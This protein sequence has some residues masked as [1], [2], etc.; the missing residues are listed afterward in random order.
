MTASLRDRP[1]ASDPLRRDVHA[2][3][4]LAFGLSAFLVAVLVFSIGPYSGSGDTEPA[5]LLPISILEDGRL[6]F[7]RFYSDRSDLPY[8]FRRVRGRVVSAYPIAA[9]IANVPAF[10][11]A[12]LFGVDLSA[13][14]LLLSHAT[15]SLLASASVVLLFLALRKICADDRQAFFFT[16]VYA[17]G[18]EVWS[19][20][21]RGLW[22]HGPSLFFLCASL[23]LLL[24]DDPRSIALAGCTLGLAVVSRPTDALI[25]VPAA[26]WVLLRRRRAF[27]PFLLLAAIPLAAVVLYS[28]RLLGDP[29]AFGQLYRAGGW[30]GRILPG[31][32]GLLVSPSRGLFVFSPVLLASVAGAV[33]VARSRDPRHEL[34]RWLLPGAAG[35][36]AIYSAWGMWWGG[37]SF[38]YRILLDLVPVLVLLA[39]VSWTE[40]IGRRLA[41]RAV[42]VVLFAVSAYV[43]VLGVWTYPTA[44]D[45]GLDLEP[46]RLWNVRDSELVLASRKLFH[47]GGAAA[48][49]G[50]PAVWWTRENEDDTIPGWLE[51]SPGGKTVVG[52]LE[53]SGWAQSAS[54]DV[55]VAIGL[56]D[57]R[58]VRPERFAR[59]DVAWAVPE[60]ADASR[61]GFRATLPPGSGFSGEAEHALT[62][63]MRGPGGR[64]RRLGPVRF[65]WRV[66]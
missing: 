11:V 58:I 42:F 57:G 14:R 3:R 44:F 63:E 49:L 38:G 33:I 65:R 40:W 61:A 36:L 47:R 56:D 62:V 37:A 50:V 17:F 35:L 19:V 27:L 9:G 39:A 31:L 55:E 66:N 26:A 46:A 4:T 6:D 20:A 24:R 54:G 12:R 16:L 52:P 25:A 15:A 48:K 45:D 28:A 32:A 29:L 5:E 41:L 13:R 51:A 34:L 60:L 18:T 8:A 22:Q 59:P 21:S 53:V 2:T 64:V 23:W 30:H 10:A 43:E 7:D 1:V